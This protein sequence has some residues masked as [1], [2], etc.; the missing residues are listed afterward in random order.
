MRI[1]RSLPTA[2]LVAA[3]LAAPAD[4]ATPEIVKSRS[5]D[6]EPLPNFVCAD[7]REVARHIHARP[8]GLTYLDAAGEPL[9]EVRQVRWDGQL[10]SADISRSVPY[11]GRIRRELDYTSNELT[12]SG[13]RVW[14]EL[15]G[16]DPAV[17]G[18]GV[19]N[20]VTGTEINR[21]R[22]YVLLRAP[23]ANSS[24]ASTWSAA[25]YPDRARRSRVWSTCHL[26]TPCRSQ[27]QAAGKAGT[28]PLS[29]PLAP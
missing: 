23:S 14:A 18:R 7:G 22:S 28:C 12:I 24:T 19:I 27:N 5:V 6:Y 29:C 15:A 16:P 9:R 4:A 3:T 20:V 17:A 26:P 25:P 2:L 11:F 8:H 21:G 1:S 10:W 13:R